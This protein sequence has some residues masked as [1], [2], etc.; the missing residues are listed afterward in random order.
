M[1]RRFSRADLLKKFPPRAFRLCALWVEKC[2]SALLV[3]RAK[4]FAL[5]FLMHM[6]ARWV[7]HQPP[8]FLSF[9]YF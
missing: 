8:L 5:A 7:I 9:R 1:Y 4:G 2:C 6:A 3:H